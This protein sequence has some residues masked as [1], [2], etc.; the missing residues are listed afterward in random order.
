MGSTIDIIWLHLESIL[1]A[2]FFNATGELM[3]IVRKLIM[4]TN[5]MTYEQ[6]FALKMSYLT[7]G[8]R[9]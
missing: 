3:K 7:E 6:L 1:I 8:G 5:M 4:H 9:E 2:T